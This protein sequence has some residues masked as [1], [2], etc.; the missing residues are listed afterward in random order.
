MI[1]INALRRRGFYSGHFSAH[2]HDRS[3]TYSPILAFSQLVHDLKNQLTIVIAC[4][5]A[6]ARIIPD[7][8][9]DIELKMLVK[10]A[11]RAAALTDEFLVGAMI[12]AHPGLGPRPTV[13][14]NA[15]TRATLPTMPGSPAGGS[16]YACASRRS[17]CLFPQTSSRSNGSWSTWC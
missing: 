8:V 10:S 6:L 12:G 2:F 3:R 14:L 13:E 7:G 5:D 11:E 17:P 9:V 16:I 15:A 4:T 1:A